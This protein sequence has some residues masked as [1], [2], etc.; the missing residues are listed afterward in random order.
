MPA[1]DRDLHA[2]KDTSSTPNSVRLR[3]PQDTVFFSTV[4]GKGTP[5]GRTP[6]AV[7]GHVISHAR[8]GGLH[9]RYDRAE[10]IALIAKRRS[11]NC[12][13]TLV[14]DQLMTGCAEKPLVRAV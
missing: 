6:S 13:A 7:F 12:N 3:F 2:R 9:H 10:L 1:I 11:S 8:L 4:L 5:A 14:S